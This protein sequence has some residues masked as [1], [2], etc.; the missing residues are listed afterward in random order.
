MAVSEIKFKISADLKEFRQNMKDVTGALKEFSNQSQSQGGVLSKIGSGLK[1]IGSAAM[2][3][4]KHITKMAASITVFKAI[5]STLNTIGT[6]VQSAFNRMDTMQTFERA[7]T[8]ITGSSKEAQE[9]LD[10]VNKTVEGTPY[11]LDVAA[12]AVQGFANS[13]LGVKNSVKYVQSWGDAVAAY[14]DG[15]NETLSRVTFQLQQMATKGKLNLEDLNS[16]MEA[17]I[18]ALQI[19][20]D[21]TG[22]T[23][24]EVRDQMADGAISAED[25]L[26]VMDTAFRDGTSQFKA[27]AGEAQNAGNL[28]VG[29]FDNMKAATT[30]GMISIIDSIDSGLKG[31]GLPTIKEAIAQYGKTLETGMK[32]L[33]SKITP[34]VTKLGEIFNKVKPYIDS[35]WSTIKEVASNVSKTLGK[36]F[37]DTG[38][39]VAGIFETLATVISSNS[40]VITEVL[41]AIAE[42][43]VGGFL[44]LVDTINIAIP[45][46]QSIIDTFN[47]LLSGIQ[48][49]LPEGTS[50]SDLVREWMPYIIAAVAGWKMLKGGLSLVGSAFNTV[51]KAASF[52]SKF[53]TL[54]SAVKGSTDAMNALSP[55]GR[56]MA[57]V[58]SGIGNAA[59]IMATVA[60][61]AFRGLFAVIMA[62]PVIAI[63]TA[64]IAVIALL[65]FKCEWFRDLVMA[66]WEVLKQVFQASVDAIIGLFTGLAEGFSQL[67]DQ[68]K[69]WFSAGSDAIGNAMTAA[70]NW[71]KQAGEVI[72]NVWNSIVN[73]VKVAV[74]FVYNI[75][76]FTFQLIYNTIEAIIL[77][78]YSIIKT[79]VDHIWFIWQAGW[80]NISNFF[81]NLWNS[82]VAYITPVLQGIA[83]FF[84][85]VW[86]GIKNVTITVWNTVK[87]A[88][89]NVWTAIVNFLKPI[90]NGIKNVISAAWNFIKDLTAT[91]FTRVYNFYKGIWTSILNFLKPIVQKIKD[92][93]VNAWNTIKEK[94]SAVWNKIKS[95]ISNVWSS[96]KSSVSNAVSAVKSKISD[97]WNTI[98]SITSSVWNGIKSVISGVWS[99]IK[100]AVSSAVSSVKSGI[101][102]A[103]SAVKS[104]T[105]STWNAIKTA[106]M[107]PINAAKNAVKKAI[108]AIKGFFSKL[109]IKFPDIKPPKL[110]HFSLDGKFS[111]MPPKVPKLSVKWYATGGIATGPSVVGIGEA[112][113]EAI[114][115]LSNKSK[116]KP[117]AN[118]V[119][120]MMKDDLAGSNS[121]SGGSG[122]VIIKE[123]T[124]IVRND[125]D[126]RKI[127]EELVRQADLRDKAKGKVRWN[128]D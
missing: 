11:G 42:I 93:I 92:S 3:A 59:K 18:P 108:D 55:A 41:S 102:S 110:P 22:Q 106:I 80:Q 54:T 78:V 81:V 14:G 44:G 116:M 68:I 88:F 82:I 9:T 39:T 96:I 104:V 32:D 83:N 20:A 107:T 70:G 91:L 103:W 35:I 127:G 17:G 61:N 85:T 58:I 10:A 36:S 105:S 27:I 7:M 51:N 48:S 115:P 99:S 118:A 34:A 25:F 38:T 71:C 74:E 114:L 49:L 8:R 26:S 72:A 76:S 33:A 119:S 113:D 46:V 98:K 67:W 77:V 128:K 69:Q 47:A 24:A 52:I 30:R 12:K 95:V 73:A 53:S 40:D 13:N 21:A 29:T 56:I 4:V 28:W 122:D 120:S 63:I 109:K 5:N 94:T 117:F 64:I 75:I 37:G 86:E 31:A 23:V 65:W 66:M 101:S 16:A 124:F 125:N 111:L 126:A 100:S 62:N 1:S 19:Y 87:S 121:G 50:L 123:N 90:I 6:S 112:G 79:T 89:I 60:M 57:S 97:I 84:K 43:G 45:V 15:S 2:G